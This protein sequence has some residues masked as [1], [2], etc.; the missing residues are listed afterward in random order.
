M[1]ESLEP[2]TPSGAPMGQENWRAARAAAASAASCTPGRPPG[3]TRLQSPDVQPLAPLHLRAAP[4]QGPA[5]APHRAH[6]ARAARLRLMGEGPP[7]QGSTLCLLSPWKPFP[8]HDQASVSLFRGSLSPAGL[9]PVLTCPRPLL[10]EGALK[11]EA[12]STGLS[13]T[14]QCHGSSSNTSWGCSHSTVFIKDHVLGS[15][16][17]A[18]VGR[19]SYRWFLTSWSL[20]ASGAEGDKK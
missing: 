2:G 1:A 16:L 17:G 10:D 11:V 5:C 3:G 20:Q 13:V 12:Y 9:T 6:P 14:Y 4:L 7:F 18:G 8:H 15:G 19:T